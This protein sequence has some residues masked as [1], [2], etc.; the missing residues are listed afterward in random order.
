MAVTQ[1]AVAGECSV[2]Q[3]QFHAL[4]NGWLLQV[5]LS[6]LMQGLEKEV[7]STGVLSAAYRVAVVI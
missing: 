3:P 6:L 2:T 5:C 4:Q 1:V 7:L